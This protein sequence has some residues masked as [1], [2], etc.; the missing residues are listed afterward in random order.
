MADILDT[1]AE[2][3]APMLAG[4]GQVGWMKTW[5][6]FAT[7]SHYAQLKSLVLRGLAAVLKDCNLGAGYDAALDCAKPLTMERLTQ[8]STD[9]Q[10]RLLKLVEGEPFGPKVKLTTE[11]LTQLK[12]VFR[13]TLLSEDWQA[14]AKAA[15]VKVQQQVLDLMAA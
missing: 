5:P 7:Y 14:I 15:A 12:A 2:V 11:R 13:E 8:S 3:T 1:E 4:I 9:I 6:Q 10:N